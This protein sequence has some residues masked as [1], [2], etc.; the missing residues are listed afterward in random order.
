MLGGHVDL[1]PGLDF[2]VAQFLPVFETKTASI[3]VVVT[4]VLSH[5]VV[6]EEK[7]EKGRRELNWR[8]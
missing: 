7:T 5:M 3:T 2:C 8:Q 6:K 1:L 4:P